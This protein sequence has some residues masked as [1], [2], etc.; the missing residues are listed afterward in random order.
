MTGRCAYEGHGASPAHAELF[1]RVR[2]LC[3]FGPDAG[4]TARRIVELFTIVELRNQDIDLTT[5]G[6]PGGRFIRIPWLVAAFATGPA[7]TIEGEPLGLLGDFGQPTGCTR[8][9]LHKCANGWENHD[10]AGGL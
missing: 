4:E 1:R 3:G 6:D 8:V 2:P 10:H 5:L 9:G 7:K